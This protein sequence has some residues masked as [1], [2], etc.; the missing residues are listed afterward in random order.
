ML[1]TVYIKNIDAD[2]FFLLTKISALNKSVSVVKD[3]FVLK[4]IDESDYLRLIS[5]KD[6]IKST[7]NKQIII[8][9]EI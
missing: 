3:T 7:Y 4:N 1:K 6:E 9:S 8:T 5:L 2:S